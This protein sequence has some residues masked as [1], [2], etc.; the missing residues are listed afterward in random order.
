MVGGLESLLPAGIGGAGCP[1]DAAFVAFADPEGN[2]FCAIG[3]GH[4]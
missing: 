3:S 4:H 2:R 1:E